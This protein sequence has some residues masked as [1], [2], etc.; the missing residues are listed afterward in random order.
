MKNKILLSLSLLTATTLVTPRVVSA[1]YGQVLSSVTPEEVEIVHEVKAAG[2]GD[3]LNPAALSGG[4]L[5]VAGM[6]LYFDRKK[7]SSLKD[8]S[9]IK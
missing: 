3:V 1:Q 4:L 5:V 8:F 7:R 9:F 2:V 6:Y